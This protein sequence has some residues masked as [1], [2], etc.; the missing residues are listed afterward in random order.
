[1][2]GTRPWQIAIHEHTP[3]AWLLS[4]GIHIDPHTPL[5]DLYLVK[6]TVEVGRVM[7]W[8][9]SNALPGMRFL[10]G[11]RL[12]LNAAAERREHTD[13]CDHGAP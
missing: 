7:F 11:D 8:R 2:S 9:R 6:W 13:M 4:L 12:L 3:G 1:M 10:F 5:I